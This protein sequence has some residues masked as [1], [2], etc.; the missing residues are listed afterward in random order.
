MNEKERKYVESQSMA[1]FVVTN[2]MLKCKDC[3][4]RDDEVQT[5]FCGWFA[6][7][8]SRKPNQVLL[9]GDC[10]AYKERD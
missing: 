8:D 4:Y 9:G 7:G 3:F 2:D 10:P 5:A 1:A 6:P